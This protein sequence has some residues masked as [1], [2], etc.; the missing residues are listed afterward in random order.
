L[1][2]RTPTF[3]E[4]G[5]PYV[6]PNDC[7]EHTRL[8]DQHN[9]LIALVKNR[10]VH[11]PIPK[12]LSG[13]ILDIGCGTGII[14]RY[15]SSHYSCAKHVYGI[16]LSPVAPEPQDS[17]TESLAFIQGDILKLAGSHSR[18]P[19]NSIDFVY[20]R[21]LVWAI[22]DWR[23]YMRQVF[24]LLKPG[25][26]AE[27]GDYVENFFFSDNRMVPC[28]E[29]EWLR[30]LRESAAF[31]GFD[32][33]AGLN[34]RKYMEEAG[35]VDIERHEYRI[36]FSYNDLKKRP[37][38]KLWMEHNIGDRWGLY[39]QLIPTMVQNRGYS[40]EDVERLRMEMRKHVDEEDGKEQVYCVTIGRKPDI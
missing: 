6:L 2:T 18:L 8:S 25:G 20:H 37:E 36:P 30:V 23:D 11:A 9:A 27:M 12:E 35:F 15:L 10:I 22:T 17:A 31:Q 39:W 13:T 7:A 29:W 26:W 3:H 19:L 5:A 28:K 24:A 34:I 32:L 14:T 21:L 16:D 4:T 33:D 40:L 38:A 1:F